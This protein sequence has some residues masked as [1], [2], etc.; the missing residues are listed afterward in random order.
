MNWNRV[1]NTNIPVGYPGLEIT[2]LIDLSRKKDCPSHYTCGLD[3]ELRLLHFVDTETYKG[4][5]RTAT[6]E[7][8]TELH[9]I[10]SWCYSQEL[11]NEAAMADAT[12][13]MPPS[14]HNELEDG[15]GCLGCS[16]CF[17]RLIDIV[18]RLPESQDRLDKVFDDYEYFER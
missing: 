10:Y 16:R 13:Y 14:C 12:C 11:R 6:N 5:I 7:P 15:N 8:E 18:M 17:G 3:R 2:C 9:K 1:K 4:W